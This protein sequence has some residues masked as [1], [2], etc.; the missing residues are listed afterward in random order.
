MATLNALPIRLDNGAIVTLGSDEITQLMPGSS[1]QWTPCVRKKIDFD[2]R[3]TPQAAREGDI[4]KG[5]IKLTV[6]AGA[7]VTDDLLAKVLEAGTAGVAKTHTIVVKYPTYQGHT[8]GVQ[9]T[10]AGVS[11]DRE[12]TQH[13]NTGEFDTVECEGTYTTV[14]PTK[15]TY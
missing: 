1:L 15:A 11:F 14:G 10:F 5:T 6:R 8:A 7:G 9:Y 2:D 13:R 3:G 12:K 4:E